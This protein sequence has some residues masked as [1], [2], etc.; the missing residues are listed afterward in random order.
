MCIDELRKLIK[1]DIEKEKNVRIRERVEA[2]IQRYVAIILA[3]LLSG[4]FLT[5]AKTLNSAVIYSIITSVVL[6]IYILIE[7]GY[8]RKYRSRTNDLIREQE[9]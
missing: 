2:D 8:L 4:G 7:Q 6:I 9:K 5:N 1:K 3:I